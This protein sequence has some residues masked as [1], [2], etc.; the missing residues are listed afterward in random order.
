MSQQ[1]YF[2]SQYGLS[3]LIG[4][5]GGGLEGSFKKINRVDLVVTL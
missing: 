4:R 1:F 3:G 2:L 5:G